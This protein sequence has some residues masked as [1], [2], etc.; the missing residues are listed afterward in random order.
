MIKILIVDDHAMFRQG[1]ITVL[2]EIVET[3]LVFDE[4]SDGEQAIKMT[5][6]CEYDV[7]LLDLSLPGQSGLNTLIVLKQQHPKLPVIILSTHPEEHFLLRT[8]RAGASGYINK[9]SA[10]TELKDAI[11]KVVS[12]KRYI[13][14][15]QAEILASSM[16]DKSEIGNLHEALSDREFQIACMLTSGKTLTEIAKELSLSVPTASSYRAR[17]LVKLNL[18]S[19]AAIIN[20][21]IQHSL[22]L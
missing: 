18:K 8:L 3:P 10:S 1:V 17:I 9:R 12:G 13:N 16:F 6:S 19:T 11:E 14:P 15:A 7:A 2:K 20:Y 21:C 22:S 4:A 5:N